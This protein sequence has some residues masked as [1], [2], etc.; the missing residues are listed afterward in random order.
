MVSSYDATRLLRR[1][2]TMDDDELKDA[3]DDLR[4]IIRSLGGD[5]QKRFTTLYGSAFKDDKPTRA[6]YIRMFRFYRGR[7][8]KRGPHK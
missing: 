1:M 7:K 8:M 3:S 5:E 6:E 2:R 4:W